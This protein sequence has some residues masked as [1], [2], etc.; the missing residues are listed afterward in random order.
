M[1]VA[2]PILGGAYESR[3]LLLN[4]QRC[5]NL[6]FEGVDSKD[7]KTPGVLYGTPGLKVLASGSNQPWRALHTTGRG[8][9]FGVNGRVLYQLTGSYVLTTIGLLASERGPVSIVDNIRQLLIVDGDKAYGYDESSGR[10]GLIALPFVN[11]APIQCAF[12]DGFF[13]LNQTN[14]AQWWQSELNDVF[15]WNALNFSSKDGQA[16]PVVAM[17][18]HDRSVWLLG[19][20]TSEVWINA[21]QPG[22]AFQRLQ[23]VFI[24]EGCA[25]PHS[26]K[27][28]ADSIM[29]LGNGRGGRGIVWRNKGYDP[30]RV[31]THAIERE[32]QS[33]RR[34][35][36]AIAYAYQQEGHEFYVLT[37]PAAD[38]TW[39]YDVSTG[40]WHERASFEAGH[41]HRHRGNCCAMFRGKV[42]VGD[43]EN[44]GLYE[45]DLNT[46]TD[47]GAK[48]KWLRSWPAQP[49]G[50]ITL[51]N[52]RHNRLQI[53]MENGGHLKCGED[54]RVLQSSDDDWRTLQNENDIRVLSGAP[55]VNCE[56]PQVM[57]RWSDSGGLSWSNEHWRSAGKVG[58]VQHRVVWQCLGSSRD[59]T[60]ELS[61]TDPFRPSILGGYLDLEPGV[62]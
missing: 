20:H 41:F 32:I 29:W 14:T 56:D 39:C 7:G 31:S 62:S 19:T 25:A 11:G 30:V 5:I 48:R 45:F 53:Y 33:Y 21:G 52:N 55:N 10:F 60:Y 54:I 3:S 40:L 46:Y 27:V 13:L 36:D 50:Q 34:I 23:G 43:F 47:A 4:S 1:Q 61:A 35:D 42:V 15:T 24:E 17:V 37:F 51:K 38:V 8:S 26:A 22:F 12:Q 16:D 9:L 44:G 28:I 6:Y 2:T 59:R 58:E 49:T 57:L 18:D